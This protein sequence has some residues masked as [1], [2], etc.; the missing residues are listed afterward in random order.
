MPKALRL[1]TPE[2]SA[3]IRAM[4][5][6][7]GLSQRDVQ[8][9]GVSYAYISRIEAGTRRPSLEALVALADKLGT[10]ALYLL[11][12]EKRGHCPVCQRGQTPH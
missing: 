8:T 3:R 12:G 5:T 9:P 7:A 4:R 1:I 2:V 10:T 6:E 11:T